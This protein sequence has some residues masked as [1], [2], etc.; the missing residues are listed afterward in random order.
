MFYSSEINNFIHER[1]RTL[2]KRMPRQL[3]K[4]EFNESVN[5]NVEKV[6]IIM[7]IVL[8]VSLFLDIYA[9]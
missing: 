4:N 6:A 1:Y 3:E 7:F 2:Q 9:K 8:V 5:E